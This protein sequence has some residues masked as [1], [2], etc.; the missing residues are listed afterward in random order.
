MSPDGISAD[1]FSSFLDEMRAV[2]GAEWVFTSPE[3]LHA[4]RDFYSVLWDEPEEPRASAALAP[5]DVEQVQAV[6][7]AANAYGI[8]LYPISTGRNLG[9][10]GAAP[11]L[12]GSVVVD[13]K[14]LNRVLEVSESNCSCLVEPGGSDF[15]RYR[16]LPVTG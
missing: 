5:A 12:S 14:R 11:V 3:D 8:P 2:L 16:Q 10:G 9:Y 4:Y 1:T 15:D 7:R 13:L 6:A